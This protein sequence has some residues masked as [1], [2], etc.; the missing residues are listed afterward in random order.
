MYRFDGPETVVPKRRQA[1][2]VSGAVRE[3]DLLSSAF[4]FV[5]RVL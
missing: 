1:E 5:L 2:R 3:I 4:A